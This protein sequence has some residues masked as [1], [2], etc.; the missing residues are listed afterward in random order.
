MDCNN[1]DIFKGACQK[2]HLAIDSRGRKLDRNDSRINKMAMEQ[3]NR[4][5]NNKTATE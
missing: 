2:A 4:Q 3:L 1:W 5:R